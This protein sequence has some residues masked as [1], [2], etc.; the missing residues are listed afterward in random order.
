IR[1][2]GGL[3]CGA[4]AVERLIHFVSRQAFDIEGLGAQHIENFW[5]DGLVREPADIFRLEKDNIVHREKWGEK[6]AINLIIAINE[7]RE[8]ALERFIYAL[9]IRHVGLETAKLL[10]KNFKSFA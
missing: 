6:S 1:C 9:G 8:I 5:K 2:T 7:R 10:A 4:Q 3:I